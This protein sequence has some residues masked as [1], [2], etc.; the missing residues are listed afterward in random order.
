MITLE[1]VRKKF[2]Y[3][4]STGAF[5]HTADLC[6]RR[7]TVGKL[8]G[9]PDQHG[10]R[11]VSIQRKT[12]RTQNLIWFWMTGSWP[13][14]FVDHID[15]D[16]TNLRWN[17]LRQASRQENCANRL[18]PNKLGMKGVYARR[19]KFAAYIKENGKINYLGLY[20]TMDEA[21]AAYDKAAKKLH[22]AFALTNQQLGVLP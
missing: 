17:N 8:A 19:N 9:S 7:H 4:P 1:L 15:R 21:A 3:N 5:T 12:Y 13:T 6:N 16:P 14:A 2:D 18:K 10:Y 20:P 22:G 11:V